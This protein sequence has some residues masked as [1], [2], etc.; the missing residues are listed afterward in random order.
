MYKESEFNISAALG[1]GKIAIYNTRS[2]ALL[3]LDKTPAKYIGDDEAQSVLI[4]EGFL[5]PDNVN[6]FD[7]VAADRKNA[8]LNPDTLNFTV[9]ST[10]QCQAKCSYCFQ[11]NIENKTKMCRETAERVANYICERVETTKS[12]ELRMLWFGGEPLLNQEAIIT[13]GE[14][15]FSKC[16]DCNLPFSSSL[17]TNGIGMTPDVIATLVEKVALKGVQVS[18]EGTRESFL[19][20]K[21]I[22]AFDRVIQ[23][24]C[25][26]A[27]LVNLTIRLNLMR[28]NSKEIERLLLYLLD[29]L[30]LDSK[31]NIYLAQV[32]LTDGCL[33]GFSDVVNGECH[34]NELVRL[35][36]DYSRCFE[37]L[38]PKKLLPVRKKCF[39]ALEKNGNYAI[40]PAGDFYKCDRDIGHPERAINTIVE[41]DA[42][43]PLSAE[44]FF[45][46][47]DGRCVTVRCPMLPACLSS[48]PHDRLY[49]QEPK[50]CDEIVL[51]AKANIKLAAQLLR[52]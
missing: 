19:R 22:D 24:I 23:N 20:A 50:T 47:L 18:L 46:E 51:G 30:S 29:D 13:I 31:V 16:R 4:N 28:D 17:I 21:G 15:V 3:V 5:V 43:Q 10:L 48:C 14:K 39:C 32:E 8:I 34:N 36:S 9:A 2:G 52:R 6:E 1:D 41:S 45:N 35:Y 7:E 40:G 49:K 33:S 25:D 26:C 12:H 42:K 44:G 11:G 27:S 38:R 37:S